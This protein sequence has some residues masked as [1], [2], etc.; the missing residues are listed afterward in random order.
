M[1]KS[2]GLNIDHPETFF[3]QQ[4]KITKIVN[5][6]PLE[7]LEMLME[8]AGV[9]YYKEIV[10]QTI[11][12]MKDKSDKLQLTHERMQ[13]NFGPKLKLLDK[14]RS[15]IA[16]YEALNSDIE[17]SMI[18]LVKASR[19]QGL[20]MIKS[21]RQ[22]L[23]DCE[24]TMSNLK[25]MKRQYELELDGLNGKT[26]N[27]RDNKEIESIKSQI[28]SKEKDISKT[29]MIM[30]GGKNDINIEN[31]KLDNRNQDVQRLKK[32]K[33]ESNS[34]ISEAELIIEMSRRSLEQIEKKL[35]DI[36]EEKNELIVKISSSNLNKE[37]TEP[38]EQR[39]KK[40]QN[41]LLRVKDMKESDTMNMKQLQ[42]EL[43]QGEQ[44]VKNVEIDIQNYEKE[45]KGLERYMERI[46]ELEREINQIESN[47]IRPLKKQLVDTEGIEKS[48]KDKCRENN[49]R[50]DDFTIEYRVLLVYIEST[51]R[52][53]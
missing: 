12:I 40:L 10:G 27:N 1:F 51:S 29:N 5:F 44:G 8:S 46:T 38:L 16:E 20:K 33:I 9:A 49:I 14:E 37:S 6:K 34:K 36:G 45:I 47:E 15:K 31:K 17:K 52:F 26:E 22:Q 28:E 24:K 30:N 43:K 19:Y 11:T 7:I 3:V 50:P 4:G 25:M 32:K 42:D 35:R 53:R 13:A 23:I 48:F 2:I 21:H 39:I 41:E 18:L